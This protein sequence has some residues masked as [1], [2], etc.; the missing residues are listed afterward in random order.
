VVGRTLRKLRN[1]AGVTQEAAAKRLGC[2]QAKINKIETTLCRISMEQLDMLIE[3]YG[4]EPDMAVRLR[5]AAAQDLEDGPRRTDMSA[6]TVLTE[7]ELEATEILC[8]HSERIPGPLK[9]ER[10]AL[11]QRRP[12]LADGKVTQVLRKRKARM[13][14]LTKPDPPRYRVILS[15]SSL[16]RV[17]GG[18][19]EMVLDQASHL[20]QLMA[21]HPRLELRILPFT[22]DVPYVDSDFELL[23]FDDPEIFDFVYVEDPG[24]PRRSEKRLELKKFRAHWS[25]LDAAALDVAETKEFLHNLLS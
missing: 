8:W 14:V 5:K 20:L 18:D 13:R 17:P 11:R 12:E 9:S 22:A 10:Y 7:R 1:D 19:P 16:Y 3:M 4:V 6:Y 21:D 25:T 23:L 2:G 24:G 15:E